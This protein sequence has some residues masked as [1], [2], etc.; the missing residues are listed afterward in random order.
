MRLNA[1]IGLPY[2]PKGRSRSGVDCWGLVRLF[3]LE[4]FKVELPSYLMEYSS[5][6]DSSSVADAVR[7]NLP[8]WS[9]VDV[10]EFGDLLVFNVLGFPCHTGVALNSN[11]FLH[12]FMNT[13]SCIERLNSISWSRRI[14][15]IY[16][17]QKI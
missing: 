10:I 17:W 9:K 16:R 4:I 11:D 5:S 12:S 7:N 1:F 14:H 13:N 8:N 3:Y 2:S 6:E 15:G